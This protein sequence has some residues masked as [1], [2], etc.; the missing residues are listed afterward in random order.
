MTATAVI[1]A[2]S[3]PVPK[4]GLNPPAPSHR[5][6]PA[7][8]CCPLSCPERPGSRSH[9]RDSENHKL[10]HS[11][12][13]SHTLGGSPGLPEEKPI[14]PQPAE[15]GPTH[16]L[17]ITPPLLPLHATPATLASSPPFSPQACCLLFPPPQILSS[18]FPR[19]WLLC[20]F[21]SPPGS[22]PKESPQPCSLITPPWLCHL[23]EAEC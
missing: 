1:L 4:Q 19:G 15:A 23:L 2:P 22:P 21:R 6:L 14:S 3:H 20:S 18:G 8:S 12:P 16:H 5:G 10:E 7:A 11:P 17:S 13:C 9:H